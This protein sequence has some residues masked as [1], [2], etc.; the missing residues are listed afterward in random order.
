MRRAGMPVE[1]VGRRTYGTGRDGIG[2]LGLTHSPSFRATGF[3]TVP[4]AGVSIRHGL[5]MERPPTSGTSAGT[6]TSDPDTVRIMADPLTGT[7]D[8]QV[9]PLEATSVTVE[10]AGEAV[11]VAVAL[12]AAGWPV[13]STAEAAFMVAEVADIADRENHARQSLAG[14]PG[15]ESWI[16]GMA[17]AALTFS[18]KSRALAAILYLAFENLGQPGKE[19]WH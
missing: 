8:T 9:T 11:L 1:S 5:R 16:P 15:Q 12:A 18:L 13:V 10:C 3:S 17:D 19:L 7:P 4:L 14:Q 2:T 6:T